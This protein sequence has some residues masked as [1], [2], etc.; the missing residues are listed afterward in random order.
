M[1]TNEDTIQLLI[2]LRVD[3]HVGVVDGEPCL[4]YG[5]NDDNLEE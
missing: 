3:F 4:I 1:A 2:E 5:G